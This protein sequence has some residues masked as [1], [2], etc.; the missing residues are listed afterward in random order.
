MTC[1]I[2]GGDCRPS[3]V[4]TG[5][6]YLP[7]AEDGLV[8]SDPGTCQFRKS[9][10]FLFLSLFM[11][12]VG[13]QFAY[14]SIDFVIEDILLLES[15]AHSRYCNEVMKPYRSFALSSACGFVY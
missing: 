7:P 6:L 11:V 14:A 13:A 10:F 4:D 2:I 15:D 12:L 3:E 9:Y 1:E 8:C 5:G